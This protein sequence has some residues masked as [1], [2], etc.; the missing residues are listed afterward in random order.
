M[1]KPEGE[2]PPPDRATT[3]EPEPTVAEGLMAIAK[4]LDRL[5]HRVQV[6]TN[7]TTSDVTHGFNIR[8]T[9]NMGRT[10]KAGEMPAEGLVVKLRPPYGGDEPHR[11]HVNGA[12]F[13]QPI[14]IQLVTPEP[15]IDEG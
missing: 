15:E 13:D 10:Y 9:D 5:T 14:K 11:L 4:A 7:R 2:P 1:P 3:E 8:L 6:F 12:F